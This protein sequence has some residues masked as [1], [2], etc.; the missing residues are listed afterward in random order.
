MISDLLFKNQ[1]MMDVFNSFNHLINKTL[2]NCNNNPRTV[3]LPIVRSLLKCIFFL[4][5]KYVHNNMY[6]IL[7]YIHYT[8]C[9]GSISM[10]V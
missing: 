10:R 3:N 8:G 2:R 1:I 5:C 4:I 7:Y 6:I 9:L